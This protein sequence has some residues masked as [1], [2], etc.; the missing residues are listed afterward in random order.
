M[1]CQQIHAEAV[2]VDI[3]KVEAAEMD[4]RWS[5]VGKKAQQRWLWHAIDQTSR[6]ILADVCG[7]H[8]DEIFLPLKEYLLPFGITHFY[9]DNGGV[10]SRHLSPDHHEVGKQNTQRIERQHLT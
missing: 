3:Q 7:T 10:Y 5:V 8:E 1:V 9:T 2:E 4:E 6:V